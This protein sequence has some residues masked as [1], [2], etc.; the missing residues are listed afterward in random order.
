MALIR[1]DVLEEL[2][3]PHGVTSQKMPFFIVTVMK[4]S[5]LTKCALFT[6]LINSWISEC[7][8][9]LDIFLSSFRYSSYLEFGIFCPFPFSTRTCL[10]IL[11]YFVL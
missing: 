3:E 5:N 1:T 10:Y 2:K 6:M 8:S 7:I 4:T 11:L 9:W